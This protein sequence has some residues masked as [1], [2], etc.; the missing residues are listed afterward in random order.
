MSENTF[1][2]IRCDL[3]TLGIEIEQLQKRLEYVMGMLTK[4]WCTVEDHTEGTT[5][6]PSK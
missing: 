2:S 6:T 1:V 3:Q 4:E 5:R